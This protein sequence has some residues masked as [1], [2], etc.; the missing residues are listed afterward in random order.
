MNERLLGAALLAAAVAVLDLTVKALLHS[1]PRFD[2]PRSHLWVAISVVELVGM[3]GLALLPSRLLAVPAGLV[4]GGTLG[5]LVSARWHGDVVPNP[6]VLRFGHGGIAF[7][8]ADL[9]FLGGQV[10]L[11]AAA[12]RLAIRHRQRLPDSTLLVRAARWLALRRA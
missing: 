6:F 11:T 1:A 9:C 10:L 5:N 12:A 2:H 3:G 7:N 8:V 4:G